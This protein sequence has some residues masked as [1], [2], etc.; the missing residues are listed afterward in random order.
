MNVTHIIDELREKFK[1]HKDYWTRVEILNDVK[2]KKRGSIWYNI[3][4]SIVEGVDDFF[5][6]SPYF[7][8]IKD[9][10]SKKQIDDE[11]LNR[12]SFENV[13]RRF[14]FKFFKDS[15]DD[16]TYEESF[17]K[18]YSLI[19]YKHYKKKLFSK[20]E[21]VTD[22]LKV[23]YDKDS[24]IKYNEKL[25]HGKYLPLEIFESHILG[26]EGEF[27]KFLNFWRRHEDSGSNRNLNK[28]CVLPKEKLLLYQVPS[29]YDYQKD[30]WFNV[31]QIELEFNIKKQRVPENLSHIS[32]SNEETIIGFWEEFYKNCKK[33]YN[34]FLNSKKES[35]SKNKNEIIEI[36]DEFIKKY[37]SDKN[38]E[39]DLF[40]EDNGLSELLKKHQ[41]KIIEIDRSYIQNF[42][43]M[44]EYIKTKKSNCI[45]T[46]NLIKQQL[47]EY[48]EIDVKSYEGSDEENYKENIKFFKSSFEDLIQTYRLL[49]LHSL[50][51]ITSLV[52]DDMIT[53]YEIYEILDKLGIFNSNH[54]NLIEDKLSNIETSLGELISSI[55]QMEKNI[56]KGLDK[57]T[58]VTE[59]SFKDLNKSIVKELQGIDSKLGFNNLLTSIQTYQTYQINKNTKS[60]RK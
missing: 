10:Y 11:Y 4:M 31:S 36:I 35:I 17:Y 54:E 44:N 42:V 45:Q 21:W 51:M 56:V 23:F 1:D 32:L 48:K 52:N 53:F 57:L 47:E 19:P 37:D 26:L 16:I 43:K 24:L 41:K 20:G 33:E 27:I 55:N 39:I 40:E 50:S 22:Y 38:D 46:F 29:D 34:L 3:D 5:G 6:I 8:F 15:N 49:V 58:Y 12:Y 2:S 9:K 60:F 18:V 14:I 7:I 25:E 13:K 28:L 59:S 30:D